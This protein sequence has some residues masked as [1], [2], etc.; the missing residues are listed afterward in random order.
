MEAEP[1]TGG[2]VALLGRYCHAMDGASPAAVLDCFTPSGEFVYYPTG[3]ESPVFR[4]AGHD[5]IGEWFTGHRDGTPIGSQTHVTVNPVIDVV[6]PDRAEVVSTFLSLRSAGGSIIV[7]STGR[8]LDEVA[9]GDDG[10]WRFVRRV[11]RGELATQP[12]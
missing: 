5:E 3:A 1:A 7:A 2:I 8:H 12:G 11:A 6:G 4:L 9:L 10:K